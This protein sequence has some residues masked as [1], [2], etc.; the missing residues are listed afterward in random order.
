M[1]ILP[2]K[3]IFSDETHF[4]SGGYVNK[5]NCRIWGTENPHAYIEKRNASKPSHC[6]VRILIK[7][8]NWAIFL[9]KRARRGRYSQWR[10]LSGHVERIFV[11]KNSR[12]AYWQHLVSTQRS[13]VPHSRRYTWCFASCFWR[14]HY[15]LQSWCHL[16]TSELRFDTVGLI[17]VGCRQR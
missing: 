2:K 10:S 8:H 11:H 17:F 13:Y 14:S 6:L 4:D 1:P 5:Q 3:I 12:E 7:R 16:A 15:Q 9:R